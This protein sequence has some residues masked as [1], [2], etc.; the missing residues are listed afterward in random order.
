MM[1]DTQCT[2]R[3]LHAILELKN[4]NQT[5]ELDTHTA[6]VHFSAP[7]KTDKHRIMCSDCVLALV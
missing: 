5:L 4:L 7:V 2:V 6:P 3:T 1:T